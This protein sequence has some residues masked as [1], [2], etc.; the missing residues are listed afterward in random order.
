MLTVLDNFRIN[1]ISDVI[2]KYTV[3]VKMPEDL[4]SITLSKK[5]G[6]NECEFQ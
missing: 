1:K 3:V 5:T 2:M 6:V 4:K